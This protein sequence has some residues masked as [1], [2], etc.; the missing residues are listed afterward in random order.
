MFGEIGGPVL[1]HALLTDV[2]RRAHDPDHTTVGVEHGATRHEHADVGAV[3]TGDPEVAAPYLSGRHGWN[4]RHR[5]ALRFGQQHLGDRS[6][7][8]FV[9]APAVQRLGRTVPN[10]DASLRIGDDSGAGERV[11]RRALGYEAFAARLRL[12]HVAHGSSPTGACF[13]RPAGKNIG[14]HQP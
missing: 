12:R 7:D 8:H 14:Q 5:V 4:G 9:L 13:R 1:E 3:A 10:E 2:L 11:E 6:S